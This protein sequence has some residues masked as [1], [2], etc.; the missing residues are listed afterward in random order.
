[1]AVPVVRRRRRA[2]GGLF[3]LDSL[4][5]CR[6]YWTPNGKLTAGGNA[7]ANGEDIATWQDAKGTYTLDTIGSDNPTG[8]TSGSFVA[9]AFD[10]TDDSI[11]TGTMGS[12][13][14]DA[15][16][17]VAAL[18]RTP[19]TNVAARDFD[20]FISFAHNVTASRQVIFCLRRASSTLYFGLAS[21]N[22]GAGVSSWYASDIALSTNTWYDV[23]YT[24]SGSALT[25]TVN[26]TAATVTELSAPGPSVGKWLDTIGCNNV[27]FGARHWPS[28]AFAEFWN[29]RIDQ[30]AW[31]S[32]VLSAT[33]ISKVQ[34][35]LAARRAL[36]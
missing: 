31:Y 25:I 9:A 2:G 30:A 10:G 18:V 34:S 15:A 33:N 11:G 3:R 6:A 19:A 35:L 29:T 7:V 23:I 24:L 16:G 5:S 36:L 8:V 17:T 26:G 4:A 27:S 14:T 12:F 22:S 13:P 32:E 21:Q 20:T 1:M 28:D